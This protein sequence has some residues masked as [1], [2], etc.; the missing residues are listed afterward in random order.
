MLK[1]RGGK[2][3]DLISFRQKPETL[4]LFRKFFKIVD[5]LDLEIS[6]LASRAVARGIDAA[7]SEITQEKKLAAVKLLQTHGGI[8]PISP[9]A[10]QLNEAPSDANSTLANKPEMAPEGFVEV[11]SAAGAEIAEARQRRRPKRSLKPLY[12]QLPKSLPNQKEPST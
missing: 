1:E 2:L 6:E 9:E 10:A 11:V 3:P 12:R 5:S 4:Q 7:C 8:S